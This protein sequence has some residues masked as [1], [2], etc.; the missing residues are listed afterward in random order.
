M[1]PNNTPH[2][3]DVTCPNNTKMAKKM[4]QLY[5]RKT[6][7]K[8]K[9]YKR[10]SQ[11]IYPLFN[12][13]LR[14]STNAPTVFQCCSAGLSIW[15]T[16]SSTLRQTRRGTRQLSWSSSPASRASPRRA[17]T[18]STALALHPLRPW[19]VCPSGTS[20]QHKVH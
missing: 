5:C 16:S 19:P 4:L 20:V 12:P 14:M 10:R 7:P 1:T 8:S 9:M 2:T 6:S 15:P 13:Q 18:S 11:I 17:P 3:C